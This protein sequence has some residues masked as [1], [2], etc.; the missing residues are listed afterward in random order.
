MG[1]LWALQESGI[2]LV[3]V[4]AEKDPLPRKMLRLDAKWILRSFI[5]QLNNNSLR[6]NPRKGPSSL[7][8]HEALP[9]KRGSK[10]QARRTDQ[11]GRE[12]WDPGDLGKET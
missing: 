9:P 3:I 12:G 7:G 1:R 4:I 11:S 6:E 10:D 5:P 8:P 2:G